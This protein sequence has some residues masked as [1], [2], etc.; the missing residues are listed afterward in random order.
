MWLLMISA[1]DHLIRWWTP[2]KLPK[3]QKKWGLE[4]DAVGVCGTAKVGTIEGGDFL[5]FWT[6]RIKTEESSKYWVSGTLQ[7]SKAKTRKHFKCKER[8]VTLSNACFSSPLPSSPSEGQCG[9]LVSHMIPL[10]V[11]PRA[12]AVLFLP[13]CRRAWERSC[14]EE[15]RERRQ[16][17]GQVWHSCGASL[18]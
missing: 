5:S 18:C 7:T 9:N 12:E 16:Q 10:H 11:S 14:W 4:A 17:R 15:T 1:R 8:K 6:W 2:R 3:T 13:R